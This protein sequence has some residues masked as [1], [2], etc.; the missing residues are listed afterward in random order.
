MHTGI[1]EGIRPHPDL[2]SHRLSVS[3]PLTTLQVTAH[4]HSH[5]H[6]SAASK[7]FLSGRHRRFTCIC[8]AMCLK[9]CT[10]CSVGAPLPA[11]GFGSDG[12]DPPPLGD[13]CSVLPLQ[14]LRPCYTCIFIAPTFVDE[15]FLQIKIN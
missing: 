6:N 15:L 7:I 5:V 3:F 14:Q 4:S 11:A 8:F 2:S 12:G 13:P 9:C 1:Q 10:F